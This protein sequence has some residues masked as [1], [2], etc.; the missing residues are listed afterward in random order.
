MGPITHPCELFIRLHSAYPHAN[1]TLYLLLYVH[2]CNFIASIHH[3]R[4][5]LNSYLQNACNV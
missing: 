2:F 1:Q 4:V 3:R 5:A